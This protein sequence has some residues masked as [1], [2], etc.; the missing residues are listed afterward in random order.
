MSSLT[1]ELITLKILKAIMRK[2]LYFLSVTCVVL[3]FFYVIL[4]SPPTPPALTGSLKST[5]EGDTVQIPGVSAYFSQHDRAYVTNYYQENFDKL[6]FLGIKLPS[7]RLNHP[8]EYARTKIRDQIQTHFLEEVVHPFRETLFINGWEPEI[9][10][11]DNP[12]S[13]NKYRIIVNDTLYISKTTLRPFYSSALV[14]IIN[15]FGILISFYVVYV[16]TKK[17]VFSK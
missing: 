6:S 5:E 16:L 17:I 3:F 13:I 12:Q 15:F 9:A 4:P 2:L 7:F 8:P 14:R 10:Y 11:K 1:L